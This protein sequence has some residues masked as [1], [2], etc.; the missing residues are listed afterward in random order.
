MHRCLSASATA[1][2]LSAALTN[3]DIAQAWGASGHRMIGELA[4][5]A[6]PLELP[7]FLRSPEAGRQI[8]EVAR[9]PDRSRGGGE[10]HDMDSDPAHHIDA[11]DDLKIS[12]GPALAALP[13]NRESYDTALRTAG[14]NEY[15]AGYL[16]YAI[17]DGW[18]QLVMDLAYWRADVAGARYAITPAERTWFLKDQY[19]REGL[20]IRDL[21]YWAHFVGDGSQP[22]HV[23]VHSDGWGNYPN[24]QKFTTAKGLHARF[25]GSFV[26]AAITA[27]DVSAHLAPYRDCRCTIQRRVSDYLVATHKEVLTLYQLEKSEAFDGRHDSGK[28]FAAARL[29]AATSELRDMIVDAWRRSA[30]VSVGYPP[31]AVRDIVSGRTNA[32]SALQGID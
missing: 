13:A 29:A 17:I 23:S 3:P 30:E 31:I 2:T 7:A 19:T 9:E 15:R 32:L 27:K 8:G 5:S 6:L 10:P 12:R 1:L 11:G 20:T 21:G 18:Q 16:P 22:M 24:P 25:E 14:T 26:R 4:S 28:G